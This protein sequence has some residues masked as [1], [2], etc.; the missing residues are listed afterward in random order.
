M[1]KEKSRKMSTFFISVIVSSVI[2]STVMGKIIEDTIK[3]LF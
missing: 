3:V 2:A 1:E